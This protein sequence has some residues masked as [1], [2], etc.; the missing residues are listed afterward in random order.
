MR[1]SGLA[2]ASLLDIKSFIVFKTFFEV[3]PLV[4]FSHAVFSVCPS[5]VRT[6]QPKLHLVSLLVTWHER[7]L[8]L[9][10]NNFLHSTRLF[11]S[12]TNITMSFPFLDNNKSHE[13]FRRF[14][15]PFLLLEPIF[16]GHI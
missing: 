5:G 9:S 15:R 16:S 1:H 7:C 13:A 2:G 8:C 12:V 4:G 14:I 6:C 11:I 3:L 10:S